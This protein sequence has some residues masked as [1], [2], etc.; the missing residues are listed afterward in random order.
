MKLKKIIGIVL[1]L[2]IV[3]SGTGGGMYVYGKHQDKKK[4][5][6]VY[7]VSE[8]SEGYS[9]SEMNSDGMVTNDLEQDINLEDKQTVKEVFVKEGQKVS[10][11]D[12][13]L[14][15]DMEQV[16]MELERAQLNLQKAQNQLA[17]DQKAL[18]DLKKTTPVA[19]EP[20]EPKDVD[21]P[22]N[23]EEPDD[24][25]DNGDTQ[26]GPGVD[27]VVPEKNG[28][29]YNYISMTAVSYDK[30][31]DGSE[32]HPYVFLCTQN[33]YVEGE[34][35]NYL[36]EKKK[37]AVFEVRKDNKKTGD[38]IT[39]WTVNGS[40]LDKVG[41][42]T[43]FSVSTKE[44]VDRKKQEEIDRL[45]EERIAREE[46][47]EAERQRQEEAE[48][49]AREAAEA[50]AE[51]AAANEPQV[52]TYTAEE[53]TEAIHEKEQAIKN[54]DL[55]I[56][57]NE[58]EVAKVQ[59]RADNGIVTSTINGVVKKIQEIGNISNEEPFM[60][61]VGSEGL[62][63]TG[64]L[65]ELVLDQ[66]KKGQIVNGYSYETG[67]GFEA[68]ITSISEYPA[69][70]NQYYGEGNRNA[71]YYP[72]TA[73]I[74]DADGLSNGTF[75]GLT[76][77]IDEEN[78]DDMIS[79]PRAMV[80]KEGAKNYVYKQKKGKLIKQY[81]KTGRIFWGSSIEILK[82]LKQDDYIAFP[83]GKT[84]KEGIRTEEAESMELYEE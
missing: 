32:K 70:A 54:D 7:Q 52:R 67:V 46:A 4:V 5:A 31:A 6:K 66:V 12:K 49:A 50:A 59:K 35:L 22:D 77:T 33:A 25:G 26:E 16:N 29:A 71:S 15:Y 30:K 75:V 55:D 13:L 24:D 78:S 74:E 83:Y 56:R 18:E 23:V 43:Q 82:G 81:V 45:E 28:Q 51:A 14:E 37:I 1:V 47:E 2:A 11:G 36:H 57:K 3:C 17:L 39:S 21:E 20:E 60:V 34:Y 63:V 41:D 80:R 62:Y 9:G 40:T 72:Y 48:E 10:V 42:D 19:E 61:V 44:E 69:E 68:K 84:A 76:M 65:S 58:L 53:L 79:I 73:Y 8:L 38:L 27:D 64:T